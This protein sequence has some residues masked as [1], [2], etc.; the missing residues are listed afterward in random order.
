MSKRRSTLSS[1]AKDSHVEYLYG[2][3]F[4]FSNDL[5]R[6]RITKR[7]ARRIYYLRAAE[8]VDEHNKPR[9]DGRY[10]DPSNSEGIG[11]V[12][13][14][15]LEASGRVRNYGR[16]AGVFHLFA[17]LEGL[18]T[19]RREAL[20][21]LINAINAAG[22]ILSSGVTT[23][24][25]GRSLTTTS[26]GRRQNLPRS[27]RRWRRRTLTRV[28]RRPPSLKRASDTS[29]LA[30]RLGRCAPMRRRREQTSPR[31]RAS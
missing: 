8:G 29:P 6:F 11:F 28:A 26:V 10:R 15:V 19:D 9:A 5:H 2:G 24:S 3:Y 27:K 25:V 16:P 17:S 21:A 7:T 1:A 13:R 31:P 14:Q 12:D 22:Y 20:D 4:F 30:V 18:L 23:T